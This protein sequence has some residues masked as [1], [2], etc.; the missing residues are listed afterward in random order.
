MAEMEIADRM[1]DAAL[2]KGCEA[3]EVFVKKSRGLSVEAKQGAVEALESS[4]EFGASIRVVREGRQGFAFTTRYDDIDRMVDEAIE[5]MKWTGRDEYVGV[6]VGNGL[7]DV[8]VFDE[9]VGNRRDEEVIH[10]ALTLEAVT[11]QSDPRIKKVRKAEV[12][13]LADQTTIVNSLGVRVS[14]ESTFYSAAVTALAQD[15]KGEGQI[16][17]DF[18]GSRRLS[19]IDIRSVA[20]RAARRA[21]ELLGSRKIGAVKV[22]VVLSQPVAIDFL[23]ILSSSLSADAVQKGRSFLAGRAG[24]TVTSRILDIIDDGAIAWRPGSGPV[25]DEGVPSMRKVLIQGGVLKGYLHNTYTAKKAGVTSTGNA[26]RGGFKTLPGVGAT[27]L[28]IHAQSS[29]STDDIVASLKKGIL[30]LNAMGVHTANPVSGDFSVGISGLWIE[31][32]ERAYPIKEAIISGNI[33]DLFRKVE[34]A[35][36]DPV[37]YG[38]TGSP[39]LLVGEMDISA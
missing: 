3:A 29:K 28:Y 37:F 1:V 8:P 36:N 7:V 14:Y 16:G 15:D 2:Q 4:H 12:N 9:A 34:A 31:G 32:G 27:N 17:W 6:S 19:D 38:S 23:E 22:P 10:D 5:G 20:A 30:I 39:G 18:A 24:Q 25:D 11:L 13:S 21:T 35:G 26:V 33:L